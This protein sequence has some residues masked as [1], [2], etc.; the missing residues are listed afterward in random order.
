MSSAAE[1]LVSR[2][3]KLHSSL[4]NDGAHMLERI[5]TTSEEMLA[6]RGCTGVARTPQ[7]MNA[8][9][10]GRPVFTAGEVDLYVHLEDK[11]GVKFARQ[12]L[13]R[14]RK[15]VVV[16]VD[17]PTTFA[18]KECEGR[19]VQ[20]MNARAMLE[21][22]TRHCLVPTHEHITSLPDGLEPMQLPK[23][24]DSDP[25]VQYHNWPVGTLVR[26]TRV[27]GGHQPTPF[28]RIVASA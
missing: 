19:G 2:L 24:L 21:N 20:F 9:E 14:E 8:L 26:I 25:I 16:S 7:T 28:Y 22:V 23:L 27:F 17:G 4:H 1:Q 5:L 12:V 15:A 3:G 10:E 11:V 13:E 6:D 18:K